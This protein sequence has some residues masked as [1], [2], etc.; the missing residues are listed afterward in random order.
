MEKTFKNVK[1]SFEFKNANI[2]GYKLIKTLHN[3][4]DH[5]IDFSKIVK[6]I[7]IITNDESSFLAD[8]TVDIPEEHFNKFE[9]SNLVWY[10]GDHFRNHHISMKLHDKE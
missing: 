2:N 10:F 3:F 1:V 9:L 6:S 5:S 8:I 4:I 7:T